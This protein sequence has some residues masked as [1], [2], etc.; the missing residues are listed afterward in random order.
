MIPVFANP[1]ALEAQ[2][3]EK[4]AIPNFLMMENAAKAMADFIVNEMAAAVASPA[5]A[6]AIIVCGKGNNGGD[7]YALARLLQ[8]K[9]EIILLCLEPPTADEAKV[10]YEMC[11]RLGIRIL[12]AV[13]KEDFESFQKLC[14]R[15]GERDFLIDC[16][17]GT[18]FHGELKAEI[19]KILE[20]MNAAG[21]KK[22]INMSNI[23]II[24]F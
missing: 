10:Q 8:N 9:L 22:I 12:D 19:K 20:I 24:N 7:G 16:I 21:G 6:R 17:Y 1:S 23:Y 3:K 2:A 18:G 4:Y 13:S 11:R 14:A 15:L 5:P